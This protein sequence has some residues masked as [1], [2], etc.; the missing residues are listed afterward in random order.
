[1][2]S[3]K[4]TFLRELESSLF[5]LNPSQH[6]RAVKDASYT[7]TKTKPEQNKNKQTNK[8]TKCKQKSEDG[9]SRTLTYA[10]KRKKK[11]EKTDKQTIVGFRM[12]SLKNSNHNY[13]SYGDFT[14]MVY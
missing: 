11:E 7:V 4:T 6:Y 8:Q 14:F 1:M 9:E 12:T 3:E 5:H 10:I 13:P 2:F